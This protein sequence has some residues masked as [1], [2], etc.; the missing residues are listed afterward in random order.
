MC[1]LKIDNRAD[2]LSAICT[3]LKICP[4]TLFLSNICLFVFFPHFSSSNR[5]R[6][7]LFSPHYFLLY[8]NLVTWSLIFLKTILA[9]VFSFL[10]ALTTLPPA[11][12]FLGSDLVHNYTRTATSPPPKPL[13][14][15]V[16]NP[17][18]SHS[19]GL[20]TI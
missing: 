12:P 6:Q 14:S 15:P 5:K 10:V 2:V 3:H 19:H 18:Y 1:D 9:L 13:I 8:S 11:P 16:F 4:T 20:L 17:L 7:F